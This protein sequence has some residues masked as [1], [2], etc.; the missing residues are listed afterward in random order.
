MEGTIVQIANGKLLVTGIVGK[1]VQI[2]CV[3]TE[4]RSNSKCH[5]IGYRY[6]S[7]IVRISGV[8]RENRSKIVQVANGSYAVKGLGYGRTIV[9]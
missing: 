6:G 5:A 2:T 9:Q 4:I 7:E 8:G 3:V 1:I